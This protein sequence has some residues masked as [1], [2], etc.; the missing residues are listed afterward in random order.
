MDHVEAGHDGPTGLDGGGSAVAQPG[1]PMPHFHAIVWLEHVQAR[2]VH[3]TPA[4][5]EKVMPKAHDHD[6]RGHHPHHKAGPR[7]GPR[8]PDD[9]DF[10]DEVVTALSQAREWIVRGP[11]TAKS[12]FVDHVERNHAALADRIVDVETVDH[13]GDGELLELAR[14]RAAAI[15]RLRPRS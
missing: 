8:E 2:V 1:A 10:L 9:K 13:P 5:A 11:G 12:A 4:E 3:F 14:R 15:D 6:G 7:A